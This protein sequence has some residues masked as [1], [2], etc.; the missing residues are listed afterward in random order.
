MSSTTALFQMIE[1]RPAILLLLL[2]WRKSHHEEIY[3][4]PKLTVKSPVF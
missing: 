1:I 4:H 2:L 3:E